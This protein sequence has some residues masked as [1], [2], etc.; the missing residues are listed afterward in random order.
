MYRLFKTLLLLPWL[1]GCVQAAW[2]GAMP[3]DMGPAAQPGTRYDFD[4]R[5][6]GD[7]QVAPVQV[8]DN[9]RQT[10]L[11]FAPGQ[12]VPA[13]FIAHGGVEQPAPYTRHEPY[14][15]VQGKWPALLMRGGGLQARADYLG[16]P[17]QPTGSDST[18]AASVPASGLPAGQVSSS[19][20]L[21]SAPASSKAY[22]VG[23]ADENMRRTLARWATL[24]GWTFH[25]EHWAV[26]VDIPLAGTADFSGDFKESVRELLATTEL[27]ERPLQPCFYGNR[28]LRVVPLSEACDRTAARPGAAS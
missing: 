13:I 9:G 12:V 10:W 15:V 2:P 6:S 8:F 14:I 3:A 23:Q 26:D 16:A 17:V 27:G 21:P 11:Q 28:V 5:L 4:W 18:A 22:R 7:R 24:A 25:P 1:S 19:A 20:S